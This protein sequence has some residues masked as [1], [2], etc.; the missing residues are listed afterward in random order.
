MGHVSYKMNIYVR[1]WKFDQGDALLSGKRGPGID[2]SKAI[3]SR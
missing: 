2:G 3:Y 1:A